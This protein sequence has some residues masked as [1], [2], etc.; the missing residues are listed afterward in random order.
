MGWAVRDVSSVM[1]GTSGHDD[2]GAG[3]AAFPF[4]PSR[5]VIMRGVDKCRNRARLG[6]SDGAEMSNPA[7]SYGN[8]T[9]CS[10]SVAI[11]FSERAT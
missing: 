4:V 3:R 11:A 7:Y 2:M 8:P 5:R 10:A 1:P 6:I 9:Y